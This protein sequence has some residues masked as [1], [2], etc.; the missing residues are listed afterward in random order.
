MIIETKIHLSDANDTVITRDN[1][2]DDYVTITQC[3]N[4]QFKDSVCIDIKDLIAVADHFR[5]D[6][7]VK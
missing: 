7:G 5:K 6:A 3:E 4:D 2:D 1:D